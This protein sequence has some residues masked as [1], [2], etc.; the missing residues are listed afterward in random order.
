MNFFNEQIIKRYLKKRRRKG[1]GMK[2][3]I[4]SPVQFFNDLE[5]NN[6]PYVVLR[7]HDEV[8]LTKGDIHEFINSKNDIDILLEQGHEN[9]IV[10]ILAS[11]KGKLDIDLYTDTGRK[12]YSYLGYPYY[13]VCMAKEILKTRE[14]FLSFYQPSPYLYAISLIYHIVYHKSLDSGLPSGLDSI[15]QKRAE[16][17]HNTLETI[18]NLLKDS[19]IAQ[20]LLAD[21][22]TL[23]NLYLILKR[24]NETMPTDLLSRWNKKDAWLSYLLTT[25]R[26]PHREL[27]IEFPQTIVFVLRNDI[28]QEDYRSLCVEYIKSKFEIISEFELSN[29]QEHA[30]TTRTR[31]GNWYEHSGKVEIRPNYV[32]IC[33]DHHPELID[34][35]DPIK[36]NYPH[37]TNKNFFIK[38]KI[39]DHLNNNFGGEKFIGI[40]S[41]DNAIESFDMINTILPTQFDSFVSSLREKI[42]RQKNAE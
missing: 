17:R 37:V 2:G 26:E 8:P 28:S 34:D 18:N 22:L 6:I 42:I 39:R 33:Y 11:N 1:R 35:N 7:W 10:K 32:L 31:G 24:N 38:H 30:L 41:S 4:N 13:P 29:E 20:P 25:E 5:K 12:G 15:P 27:A 19:N 21:E 14:N 40:H 9:K 3:K 23:N 36:S 16:D